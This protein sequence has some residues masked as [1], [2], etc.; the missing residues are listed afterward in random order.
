MLK[1]LLNK[2]VQGKS[3]NMGFVRI[4]DR[5][6]LEALVVEFEEFDGVVL[7]ATLEKHFHNGNTVTIE[8]YKTLIKQPTF[9]ELL[10][11]RT[12]DK[13]IKKELRKIKDNAKYI[14]R[15]ELG[16]LIMNIFTP[17]VNT[18]VA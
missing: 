9:F 11:G 3:K 18:M 16:R 17:R 1:G 5:H 8:G 12:M 15:E 10:I 7:Y 13:K 2:G 4:D 14:L 6:V